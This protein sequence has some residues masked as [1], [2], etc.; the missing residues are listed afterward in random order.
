MGQQSSANPVPKNPYI[1]MNP[2]RDRESL[3]MFH[4]RKPQ[5][6]RFYRDLAIRQSVSIRGPR[7]TGKTSF[8]WCACQPEVQE[9]FDEDLRRHLFVLLDLREAF[10]HTV[11]GFFAH[12]SEAIAR[13]ARAQNLVLQPVGESADLYLSVLTQV[14]DQGCKLVLLLDSFDALARN[15]QFGP[16]FLSFLRSQSSNGNVTY[17]T[18][19]IEPLNKLGH[20]GIKDSPFFNVFDEIILA[21]LTREEA[22]QLIREPAQREGLPFTDNEV[23][24]IL[25]YAG[26]HLCF[27]RRTCAVLFDLKL[28]SANQQVSKQ[29]FLNK[30]YSA[31]K[32]LF[33]DAWNRL[34]DE[35]QAAIGDEVQTKERVDYQE[36]VEDEQKDETSR[37]FSE[38]TGSAF[39]R[40]FVRAVNKVGLFKMTVE[41]LEEALEKMHDLAALGETNLR[42]MKIVGH[43]LNGNAASTPVERGK[44]I[45]GVLREALEQLRG[46]GARADTEPGWYSYNILDYR[47]FSRYRPTHQKIRVRLEFNNDRQYFRKRKDA[48]VALL[49]IL[50][51]MEALE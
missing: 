30:A 48:I 29:R 7:Q 18:A 47:Y 19:S 31:L 38:L 27:I 44:V 46:P 28:Q 9:R 17:V 40:Q 10:F 14:S 25:K 32:P 12:V 4:G 20:Q 41:E 51:E 37:P 36:Q 49:N 16:D 42:L 33:Q 24:W 3:S 22:E 50:F 39:F 34:S 6:R 35:D 8:L 23:E 13:Q 43:R 15:E 21:E 26:L 5:L 11:E 2:I 1:S 45:Q